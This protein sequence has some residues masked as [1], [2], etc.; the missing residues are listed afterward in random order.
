[1]FGLTSSIK[2]L[3]L[4]PALTMLA[5]LGGCGSGV[6]LEGP[7]FEALGISGNKNKA[8]KKVP[9]RAPLLIPPD[10]AR[11][12]EPQQAIAA[13][14]PQNWPVDPGDTLKAEEAEAK[15][16]QTAYEQRGDWSKKADI[17]EFD[18]LMD[19]GLRKKGV[20]GGNNVSDRYRDY[21]KHEEYED[22][23]TRNQ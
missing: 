14:P 20:F 4:V 23:A 3:S 13:A 22:N 9:D 16:K 11:I 21:K 6:H 18:K 19:P 2:R 17:D 12:P 15:R 7:G 1:M 10:R 8:D 5:I